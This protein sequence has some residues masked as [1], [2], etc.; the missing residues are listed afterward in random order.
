MNNSLKEAIREAVE[1]PAH[2]I[3]AAQ[4]CASDLMN[5]PAYAQKPASGEWTDFCEDDWSHQPEDFEGVPESVYAGKVGDI[6]RD[7]ISELPTLYSNGDQDEAFENE[8]N[9][10][11]IDGEWFEPEPYFEID[12]SQVVEALFGATIAK[13]FR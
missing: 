12:S 7:F 2:I 6:L 10:E 9:G 11:E 1:R 13:E 4:A 8:P 3:A 5:G